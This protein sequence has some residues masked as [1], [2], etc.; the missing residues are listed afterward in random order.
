L[1]GSINLAA[2]SE[3][4]VDDD[5]GSEARRGGAR[6]YRQFPHAA[7]ITE[8]CYRDD[9]LPYD[10]EFTPS[11]FSPC[12]YARQITSDVAVLWASGWVDGAG[13][14]NDGAMATS[15]NRALLDPAEPRAL[16]R[17]DSRPP[18]RPNGGGSSCD[19]QSGPEEEKAQGTLD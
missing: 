4:R 18:R 13:Y 7:F 15:R 17:P 8:F 19:P 5:P 10:A 3:A 11:S 16:S 9:S 2:F 12:H 14:Q 1:S 6:A